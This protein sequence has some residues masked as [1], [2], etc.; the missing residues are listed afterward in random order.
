MSEVGHRVI[1]CDGGGGALGHPK[2]YINLVGLPALGLLSVGPAVPRAPHTLACRPHGGA[3][4][5]A[6]EAALRLSCGA[7]RSW[8]PRLPSS[9][10]PS[11]HPPR[12]PGRVLSL[13]LKPQTSVPFPRLGAGLA[14]RSSP[15]CLP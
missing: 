4:V 13:R 11:G 12:L 1:S 5:E 14:G 9:E 6:L 2:V 3:C 15:G 10:P 7:V 8:W